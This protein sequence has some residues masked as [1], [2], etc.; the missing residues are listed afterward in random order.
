MSIFDNDPPK[1]LDVCSLTREDSVN[2]YKAGSG[3]RIYKYYLA[4]SL[5]EI[6]VL[7]AHGEKY[8]FSIT[9]NSKK[10]YNAAL[11]IQNRAIR[12]LQEDKKITDDTNDHSL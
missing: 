8:F 11:E 2:I 1:H 12:Y 3:K 5:D 4:L 6:R 7:I 10:E 9:T